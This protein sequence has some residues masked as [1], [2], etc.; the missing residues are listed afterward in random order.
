MC[1]EH[2][3]VSS[4]AACSQKIT[5]P[6]EA[7]LRGWPRER[8]MTLPH[9]L[10]NRISLLLFFGGW[11]H[12][13]REVKL[14]KCI[15]WRLLRLYFWLHQWKHSLLQHDKLVKLLFVNNNL[16]KYF[17]YLSEASQR[18]NLIQIVVCE[19]LFFLLLRNQILCSHHLSFSFLHSFH[20]LSVS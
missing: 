9:W 18:L 10:L 3:G 5:I 7:L 12:M 19:S 15:S 8:V 17:T 11:N 16:L 20:K 6:Y 14:I 13:L 1:P 2:V 4:T